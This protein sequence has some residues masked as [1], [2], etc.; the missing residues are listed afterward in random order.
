MT[1]PVFRSSHRR[2][3]GLP[4]TAAVSISKISRPLLAGCYPRARL[5]NLLDES[6]A[7]PAVWV[8]GPPGSG[9]TTVV[10]GYIEERALPCLCY[11]VDDGDNDPATFFH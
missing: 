11:D 7:R 8:S 2:R 9:K 10:A 5:F 1:L 6:R 4:E 3:D